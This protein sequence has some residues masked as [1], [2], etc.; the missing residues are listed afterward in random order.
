MA[1]SPDLNHINRDLIDV[2]RQHR[3]P[4]T[5]QAT[6]WTPVAANDA[7]KANYTTGDS[8][9]LAGADPGSDDDDGHM[10]VFQNSW[11]S[12]NAPDPWTRNPD[13]ETDQAG[14]DSPQYAP[15]EFH[16]STNGE[17]RTH[18]H[19]KNGTVGERVFRYPQGYRPRY[20]ETFNLPCDNGGYAV[21]EVKGYSEGVDEAG[22]LVV[23]RVVSPTTTE[24]TS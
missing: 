7:D 9:N 21:V 11:A 8:S 19:I 22:W 1:R 17:T 3:R 13:S 10:P 5:K 6:E 20:T 15:V 14:G 4:K 16:M 18:G 2:V 23:V 12:V 24:T